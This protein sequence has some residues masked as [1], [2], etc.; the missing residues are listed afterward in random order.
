MKKIEKRQIFT[1]FTE[2][3]MTRL[4]LSNFLEE[5]FVALQSTDSASSPLHFRANDVTKY[6]KKHG[7]MRDK[8]GI[9]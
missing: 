8:Y 4:S 1:L 3:S 6:G 2:E 7:K 5:N 9:F